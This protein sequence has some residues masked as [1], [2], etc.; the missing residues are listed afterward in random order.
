MYNCKTYV[1]LSFSVYFWGVLTY[2]LKVAWPATT[3]V[4]I[5]VHVHVH[6]VHVQVCRVGW[7]TKLSGDLNKILGMFY[8]LHDFS[9]IHV[10]AS[11]A[12]Q[13]YLVQFYQL[14]IKMY[15]LVQL[16]N[17]SSNNSGDTCTCTPVYWSQYLMWDRKGTATETYKYMYM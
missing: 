6:S 13:I 3:M 12:T 5:P 15:K 7:V 14:D 4:Y 8:L 2:K 10:Y 17:L 1:S 16:Q 11:N 9:Y